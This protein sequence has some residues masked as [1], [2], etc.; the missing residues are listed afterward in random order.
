MV[1]RYSSTDIL[2]SE[3]PVVA[4][5]Y[6]LDEILRG[7][8]PLPSKPVKEY[9][10]PQNRANLT[11]EQRLRRA[12]RYLA[13]LPPAIQGCN[14]S[15]ATFVAAL[16]LMTVCGLS[17]KEAFDL[18]WREYNP[19]CCPPWTYDELLKKVHDAANSMENK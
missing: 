17:D 14:G 5:K 9:R 6:S 10:P 19:R 15:R 12:S 2:L 13:K 1:N 3:S 18:L 4:M 16:K 7:C 11:V 8:P